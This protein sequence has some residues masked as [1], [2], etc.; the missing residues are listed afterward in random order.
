MDAGVTVAH[1]AVGAVASGPDAG[2]FGAVVLISIDAPPEARPGEG[3]AAPGR[4]DG[5]ASCRG[6]F[7]LASVTQAPVV[8]GLPQARQQAHEG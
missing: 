8:V 6:F 4:V 2:A 7:S 5:R 3:G 1:A